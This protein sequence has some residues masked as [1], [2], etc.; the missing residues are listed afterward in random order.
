MFIKQSV[1]VL[2]LAWWFTSLEVGESMIAVGRLR[3]RTS[4]TAS[5]LFASPMSEDMGH[6][7]F[8]SELRA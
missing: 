7:S 6:P 1:R 5:T 8:L 3:R 2:H 4:R